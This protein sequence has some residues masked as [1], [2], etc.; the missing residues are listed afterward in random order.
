M[1]GLIDREVDKCFWK[2][3]AGEIIALFRL[4]R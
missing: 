1:E 4:L 2:I 3:Q